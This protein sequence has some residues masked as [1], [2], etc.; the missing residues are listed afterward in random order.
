MRWDFPLSPGTPGPSACWGLQGVCSLPTDQCGPGGISS[1]PGKPVPS[2]EMQHGFVE[3][4]QCQGLTQDTISKMAAHGVTA[5][6]YLAL[7]EVTDIPEIGVT[8]LSQKLYLE[9][10]IAANKLG[11]QQQQQQPSHIGP[12]QC[13]DLGPVLPVRV[14]RQ[15]VKYY[16]IVDFVTTSGC[17]VPEEPVL[18][19]DISHQPVNR[20]PVHRPN[21]WNNHSKKTSGQ[22]CEVCRWYNRVACP[23]GDQCK[24]RH[25]CLA[26]KCGQPHPLALHASQYGA[27]N[28]P[29]QD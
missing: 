18:E 19:A 3:W 12:G 24:Y 26:P 29:L 22:P 27:K 17:E 7:M 5:Q 9:Q 21:K 4:L 16:D 10:I 15:Q 20:K 2:M 11:R 1:E 13:I 8:Q 14:P 28:L 25:V 6:R 23:F